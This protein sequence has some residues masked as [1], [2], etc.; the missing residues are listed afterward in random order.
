MRKR[1]KH[2]GNDNAATRPSVRQQLLGIEPI[3]TSTRWIAVGQFH[4]N[5]F[6]AFRKQNERFRTELWNFKDVLDWSTSWADSAMTQE[7]N[8]NRIRMGI[9]FAISTTIMKFLAT[10]SFRVLDG[11]QGDPQTK[12]RH[13]RFASPYSVN[14]VEMSRKIYSSKWSVDELLILSAIIYRF[15]ST[16]RTCK[17]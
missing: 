13:A 15:I 12:F 3:V 1:K 16:S 11:V 2:G 6:L 5:L 10:L 8:G 7:T 14:N 9:C 17:I 4:R